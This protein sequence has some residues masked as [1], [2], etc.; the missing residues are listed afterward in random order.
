MDPDARIKRSSVATYRGNGIYNTTARN[1]NVTARVVAGNSAIFHIKVQNDGTAADPM[2]LAGCSRSGGFVVAY[3]TWKGTDITG[4][5]IAGTRVTR[6]LPAGGVS[7]LI[8]RITAPLTAASGA[9]RA[10]KVTATSVSDATK[11]DGV[12]A[13]LIVR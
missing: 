7:K 4:E 13:R 12:K 1:Q 11:Q 6:T 5:V 2:R 9:K 3:S 8:L 10:C